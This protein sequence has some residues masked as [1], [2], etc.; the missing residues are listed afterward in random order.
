MTSHVLGGLAGSRRTLLHMQQRAAGGRRG[1]HLESIRRIRN[2]S[3]SVD[4]Y[5]PEEQYP[6]KFHPDPI[7]QFETT[8][9]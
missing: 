3:P 5:L 9:P 6:D 4:T 1:R 8:E 2:P 7:I